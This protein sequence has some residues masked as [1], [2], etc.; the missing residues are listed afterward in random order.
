MVTQA[1]LQTV[2]WAPRR[3]F[4][5]FLTSMLTLESDRP[6]IGLE[7]FER[8][9]IFDCFG[10]LVTPLEKKCYV[11]LIEVYVEFKKLE[12]LRKAAVRPWRSD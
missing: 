2:V 5:F 9:S 1:K 4:L 7:A 6:E 3:I 11:S 12:F 8:Q 10:A